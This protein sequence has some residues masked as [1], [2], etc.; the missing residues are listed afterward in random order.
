MR[1]GLRLRHAPAGP[2]PWRAQ[3]SRA[4]GRILPATRGELTLTLRCHPPNPP[5][6]ARTI[7]A[8]VE[9]YSDEL[10]EL[11]RDLHAHPELSRARTAP[12]AR[13]RAARRA[14]ARR[15][16]LPRQRTDR[17]ARRGGP[18]SPCAPTST[19]CPSRRPRGDPWAAATRAS[20]TRAATTCTPPACSAPALALAEAHAEAC[21]PAG[22]RLLFQ[23]AEEVMPGGALDVIA[24]GRARRRRRGSSRCTAT[25]RSTSGR[26]GL[27][28]G[29]ITGAADRVEVSLTGRGGHTSRPH[30]T[31]DLTFA[32]G[33]VVTELPAVLSPPARPPRRRQP[34]LGRGP[35]RLGHNVIPAPAQ[36]ARHAAHARRRSRGPTPRR[37][38]EELIDQIV[39]PYGVDGRGRLHPGRAAGGQ[40]AAAR[41][42]CSAGAVERVLGADGQV[43]DDRRASA[44]RTSRGTSSRCRARWPGWAPARP[45]GRPTTCTRATCASTSARWRSAPGCW[46]RRAWL[47]GHAPRGARADR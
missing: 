19:R 26:S 34:G 22:V 47:A 24:G 1:A 17:R 45:A 8:V 43:A 23:P 6:P 42:R 44:A 39:A 38:S 33:K 30:L 3:G 41:P 12:P 16:P 11:R 2:G 20:P 7:E 46:P 29:P 5:T 15:H 31:E 9:K 25:R 4:S 10:V 37:W 40:R 36:V 13:R 21:C 35:G 28:V 14:G 32:L 18:W 27:R